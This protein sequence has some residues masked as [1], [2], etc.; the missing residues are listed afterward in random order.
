VRG[1]LVD[2]NI[3]SELRRAKPAAA[4]AKFVAAQPG[5]LLFTTEA[6]L[7]VMRALRLK[8]KVAV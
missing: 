6:V 3:V 2:T 4:V 5:E 1:W 8:L 7:K